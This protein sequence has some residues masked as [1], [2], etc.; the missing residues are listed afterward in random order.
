MKAYTKYSNKPPRLVFAVFLEYFLTVVIIFSVLLFMSFLNGCGSN[1]GS[2]HLADIKSQ[3]VNEKTYS[4]V[5]EDMKEEGTFSKNFFHKYL[6]VLPETSW[7]TEW[8]PVAEEYFNTCKP[9]MGMTLL[10]RKDGEF[11]PVAAPP[12]Y[13]FVGDPEYGRWREGSDGASFWEFYGKYAFFS[14]LFGG[15]YHPIYKIDF[16][17]YHKYKKAKKIYFG[18]KSQY[19]SSGKIVKQTKPGFY[20]SRMAS[21]TAKKSS[22][23]DKVNSKIGRTKTSM[24]SRSGGKGK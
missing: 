11:D 15:W 14:N 2:D 10:T 20:Q 21:V 7:K 22:F 1:A 4:I 17:G 19:G 8:M 24:R 6:V 16:D 3:L 18:N 5:L 9:L 12:G 23:T 13:A